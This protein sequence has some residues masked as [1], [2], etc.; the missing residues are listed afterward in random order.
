MTEFFFY[1]LL[2]ILIAIACGPFLS[3]DAMTYVMAFVICLFLIDFCY[4]EFLIKCVLEPLRALLGKQ[5][6][7]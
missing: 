4:F 7:S 3:E 2:I 1:V 5:L 6:N